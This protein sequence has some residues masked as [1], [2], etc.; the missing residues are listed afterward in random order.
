MERDYAIVAIAHRL[1]TVVGADRIYALED[2]HVAESGPHD[3]L[4]AQGGQYADLYA[5]Q[6]DAGVVGGG[7]DGEAR[8]EPDGGVAE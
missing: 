8:A 1:S 7:G 5:T 3:E 2:G 4:L 6:A